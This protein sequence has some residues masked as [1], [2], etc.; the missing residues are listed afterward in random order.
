[1]KSLSLAIIK[2]SLTSEMYHTH[3]IIEAEKSS[4]NGKL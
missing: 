1:M 2:N 3:T 4:Q